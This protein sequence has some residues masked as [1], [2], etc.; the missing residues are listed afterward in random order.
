MTVKHALAQVDEEWKQMEGEKE[1]ERSKLREQIKAERKKRIDLLLP[2]LSVFLSV[3]GSQA[4][5]CTSTTAAA[6]AAAAVEEAAEAAA[7]S[8]EDSKESVREM[9]KTSCAPQHRLW[10]CEGRECRSGSVV[11]QQFLFFFFF[12]V[13]S[14]LSSIALTSM[15][16]QQRRQKQCIDAFASPSPAADAA[17]SAGS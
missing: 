10:L 2:S 6:E 14:V 7:A 13:F 11:R 3:D 4:D 1:R 16:Q 8:A 17:S 5:A 15:Q 9:A 12:F